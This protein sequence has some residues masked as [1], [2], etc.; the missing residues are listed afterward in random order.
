MADTG[1]IRWPIN[2]PPSSKAAILRDARVGRITFQRQTFVTHLIPL[3]HSHMF[4]CCVSPFWRRSALRPTPGWRRCCSERF[5]SS[6]LS[7]W[8]LQGVQTS[9]PPRTHPPSALSGTGLKSPTDANMHPWMNTHM[10]NSLHEVTCILFRPVCW[11]TSVRLNTSNVSSLMMLHDNIIY[12]IHSTFTERVLATMPSTVF[13]VKGSKCLSCRLMNSGFSLYPLRP[14]YSNMKRFSCID[15][16]ETFT[17]S[18]GE[19]QHYS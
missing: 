18:S 8:C 17:Y 16:S 15:K 11:L 6:A 14:L 13:S 7:S 2:F 9:P 12:N 19:R 1:I 5:S 10:N 3:S 4:L